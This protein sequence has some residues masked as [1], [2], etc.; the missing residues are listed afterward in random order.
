MH[1]GIDA[2][3]CGFA[4]RG[5][6][7]YLEKLIPAL[8][9]LADSHRYTLFVNKES[10]LPIGL[11]PGK[12]KIVEVNLPWYGHIEQLRFPFILQKAKLDLMHWPNFNVPVFCPAPFVVTIHDLVA[13]HYPDKRATTLPDWRWRL[14]FRGYLFVLRRALRSAKKIITVSDFTKRDLGRQ[15][16][17]DERK[18]Q[19]I[20]LGADK[21]FLET[22]TMP[23][24]PDFENFIQKSFGINKPYLLC[25]GSFYP[26]KNLPVLLAAFQ[27]LRHDWR[28]DWQLALVGRKDYFYEQLIK[29]VSLGKDTADNVIFTDEVSDKILDGFYRG[30]RVFVFPSY[31]EGFGLPPLEAAARGLPVIAAKAGAL[32][33]IL[34]EA[35]CYF[36]PQNPAALAAAMNAVGGSAK[37]QARLAQSGFERLKH[38]DWD[39]T[40]AE[41]MAVYEQAHS[42]NK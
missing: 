32:P 40:A 24:P 27:I 16:R 29:S 9:R 42:E 5:I 25:V 7:R 10:C 36:D 15:L 19:T 1:I 33:E 31:Y 12:F 20:Y 23:N 21:M 3:F 13:Y 14:K 37:I 6:G 30:A 4:Q 26:H 39:K 8:G 34:G 28:R 41:T 17:V 2:R 38:F 11:N 22:A 35:A 18:I